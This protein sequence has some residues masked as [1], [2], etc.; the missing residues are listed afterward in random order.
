MN[1]IFVLLKVIVRHFSSDL[2][3]K[4]IQKTVKELK[5]VI[6]L[7]IMPVL[8]LCH[9]VST[10]QNG[11]GNMVVKIEDD[12][13]KLKWYSQE[14]VYPKG[15][16]IFRKEENGN[17][18]KLNSSP[19]KK[20]KPIEQSILNNDEELKQSYEIV[21]DIQ[22]TDFKSIIL[23]NTI[24]QSFK[25]D[26]FADFLG[27]YFE[28]KFSTTK[29]VKYK[30]VQL[31]NEIIAETEYISLENWKEFAP[32]KNIVMKKNRRKVGMSWNYEETKYWA[33]NIYRAKN[34][35]E[36]VKINEYPILQSDT[37]DGKKPKYIYEDEKLDENTTYSYYLK[38][39]GFFGEESEKSKVYTFQI[40]D[41]TPPTTP[42]QLRKVDVKK[43]KVELKWKNSSFLSDAVGNNIYRSTHVDTGY[44]KVNNSLLAISDT[45]FTDTVHEGQG[46]FYYKVGAIDAS[47]NVG[48]SDP[49]FI[50][51]YDLFAP[52]KPKNFTVISDTGKA[53]FTWERGEE[54]DLKRVSNLQNYKPYMARRRTY[55]DQ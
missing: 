28:D 42:Y 23:L 14:L 30:V 33:V 51:V 2:S 6:I 11:N 53:I 8:F 50:E 18:V 24:V 27:I 43:N 49:I 20:G 31:D 1:Y 37:K 9:F 3:R 17:W 19:I 35:E 21:K 29:K 26:E 38:G 45:N 10:A 22:P 41:E 16:N 55:V 15:V 46:Y 13:I 36:F 12:I 44:V 47:G 25:S 32:P 52:Q 34:N 4:Y 7:F 54:N 5:R 48:Y 39:L 40:K